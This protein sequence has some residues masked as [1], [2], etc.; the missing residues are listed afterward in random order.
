MLWNVEKYFNK[1]IICYDNSFQ[2]LGKVVSNAYNFE[3]FNHQT[4]ETERKITYRVDLL[5]EK[6]SRRR[7]SFGKWII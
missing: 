2:T 6:H 3:V 4:I 1:S 7:K 5:V